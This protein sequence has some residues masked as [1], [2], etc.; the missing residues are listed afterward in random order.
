[1]VGIFIGI[2]AV[3]ALISVSM[4]LQGTIVQQFEQ[5]GTN[6]LIVMP[7]GGGFVD[8]GTTTAELTKDDLEV[9]EKTWG[10]ETTVETMYTTDRLKMRDTSISTFVIGIPTGDK[11]RLLEEMQGFEIESGRHLKD[12]D[13]YKI[14][15]GYILWT[16]DVFDRPVTL[17]DS[18]E[19]QGQEF[20]VV[21]LMKKIGNRGDDS[22]VY[23][24]VDV[25]REIYDEPDKIDSIMVQVKEGTT[26]EEVAEELKKELRRARGEKEGEE[27]FQVQTFEQLISQVTSILGV[28]GVVV[29]GIAAISI[30]VGGVGIMNTMYTSVLER[31]KE[32]GIMKAV[33]ARNSNILM[34]FLMES[35]LIG[36]AGGVVGVAI[37]AGLA[38]VIEVVIAQQAALPLV[39]YLGAPLIAGALL[40]SFAIGASSGTLPAIQASKLKPVDALRYE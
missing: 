32:I 36:L 27:T 12:G 17:R 6:K 3:V 18:I 30:V 28:V 7:G 34:L 35:G 37:G 2:A 39:A 8:I 26:P 40:F 16:E 11:L 1:M 9:I 13:R 29:V 33:G 22:Q 38:K 15:V 31:T 24:P 25:Y 19:I 5:M 23:I 4:G 21:G 14:V 10:V 20:K